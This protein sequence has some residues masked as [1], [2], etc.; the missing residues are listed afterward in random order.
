M[1]SCYVRPHRAVILV[2]CD[3][4]IV[5]ADFEHMFCGLFR[6]AVNREGVFRMVDGA[7]VFE[8]CLKGSLN[9]PVLDKVLD[10]VW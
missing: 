8:V 6:P 1:A 5:C 2:G 10:E 3:D 7:P 9:L 4:G